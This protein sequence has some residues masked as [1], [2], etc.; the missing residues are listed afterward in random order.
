MHTH[1]QLRQGSIEY[2]YAWDSQCGVQIHLSAHIEEWIH[3]YTRDDTANVIQGLPA[4]SHQQWRTRC[5]T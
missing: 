5:R 4:N 2:V 1:M 3:V